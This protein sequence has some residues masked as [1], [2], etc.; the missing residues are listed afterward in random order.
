MGGSN[1]RV[2][3]V[4][5]D[6]EALALLVE[7]LGEAGYRVQP[8][9]SGKL[10]LVSVA[11][12]PPEL[13]LLDVRMPLMDGFEVC[14]RLRET[15]EGRR[16]PVMFVSGS[17]DRGEWARGLALGAVD[18][19]SK[20]FLREELLARVQTHLEL[21]R[22]RAQLEALVQQRTAELREALQHVQLEVAE[23]RRAEQAL[24]ESELRFRE[25][26]NAAPAIIWTS[27]PD[28]ELNFCNQFARE[29]TG[30]TPEEH[31][32]DWLSEAVHPE[33]SERRRDAFLGTSQSRQRFELEY[34]MRSA[35]G[36]YRWILDVATPRFGS[37]GEFAGY[38]GIA[39]DVTDFKSS[40]QRA[41]AAQ[42]LENLRVLTAGIAHDFNN[43]IGAIYGEAYLASTDMDPDAPGRDNVERI[44]AV[45]QRAAD[46]VKLLIAYVGDEPDAAPPELIDLTAVV[47]ELVPH[48]K[49]TISRK[50]EIRTILAPRLPSI[51]ARPHQVRQIVLNL[52]MNAVEALEG[53][54]GNIS[55]V[56]STIEI[57]PEF[58]DEET[59]GL[60]AGRYVKLEVSDTGCGMSEEVRVRIFDPYY[61]TKFL[62]RGLGLAAVQG[63]IRSYG[64][65]I[66]ARSTPEVGSTFEV[67]FPSGNIASE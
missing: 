49:K 6:P 46:V 12:L 61:T 31:N 15:D 47:E 60:R 59:R 66:I 5:D 19:I 21:G 52:I 1:G 41:F 62:G 67:L 29:F 11:A 37:D 57:T 25:L 51:R 65:R 36:E 54:K 40:Q 38:V 56:T 43:L 32:P 64:G 2:L 24:R 27:G 20:P 55:V 3:V 58:D 33:D 44:A 13:I 26:A 14:R 9:D 50:A 45:A 30:Q 8:A 18:F 48:L 39:I 53:Q 23:R 34:R 42:N 4:D 16:I 10:A 63:I 17:T 35:S 28:N 22:L 7:T